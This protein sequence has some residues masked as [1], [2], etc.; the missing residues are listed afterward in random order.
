[1]LLKSKREIEIEQGYLEENHKKELLS[2]DQMFNE[3][4]HYAIAI[5]QDRDRKRLQLRKM[6]MKLELERA[7]EK[8]LDKELEAILGRAIT[9]AD[10][11][12][13]Y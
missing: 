13:L 4:N 11:E 9:M 10:L 2:A 6:N 8:K 1:M 5:K 3:I 12:A 7:A